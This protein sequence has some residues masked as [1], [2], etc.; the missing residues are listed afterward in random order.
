MYRLVKLGFTGIASNDTLHKF[1]ELYRLVNN[2]RQFLYCRFTTVKTA[3][4]NVA[5]REYHRQQPGEKMHWI[6]EFRWSV[7]TAV[8]KHSDEL[9]THRQVPGAALDFDT[10]KHQDQWQ[11]STHSS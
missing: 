1:V 8:G 11:A 9:G 7:F 4:E 6:S 3:M 2:H 10:R 5:C